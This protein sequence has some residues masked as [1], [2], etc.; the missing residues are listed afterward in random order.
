MDEYRI[1][2]S[3]LAKQDIRDI[4]TH[5]RD[6]LLNPT[7]AENTTEAILNGISK[8]DTNTFSQR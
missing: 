8:L 1:I 3:N 2:I 5:I 7:A 6:E 4:G